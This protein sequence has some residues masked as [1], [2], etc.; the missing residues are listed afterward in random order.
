MGV[1]WIRII[2]DKEMEQWTVERV[3]RQY[4]GVSR[5]LLRRAKVEENILLNGKRVKSNT[6]VYE[7]DCLELV[8][9]QQPSLVVPEQ[10][11]LDILYEDSD[12]LAVN[13]PPQMLVHPLTSQATGT[14]ANAVAYHWQKQGEQN[15]VRLV[16]RLDR[17]TSGTVLVAKNPYIHQQLQRQM[18]LGQLTRRYLAAVQGVPLP[19]RGI[20]NAPI[21]LASGSIIQRVVTPAGKPAVSH[22]WVLRNFKHYSLVCLELKT[23]RTHQVRVHMA[24]LGHPL[25]GDS[26]YGGELGLI[27]RQALHCTYLAFTHPATGRPMQLACPL[28]E[29]IKNLL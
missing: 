10:I 14:L 20:I 7:G 9:N 4:K 18:Q 17:D 22:Y 11:K 13:K 23:G 12:L 21:G 26:L 8:M 1:I 16:H 25:L 28:P 19:P 15:L 27:K 29:D 6:S 2:I 3:L 5:S 24:H